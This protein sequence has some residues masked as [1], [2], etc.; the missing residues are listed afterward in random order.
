ME[1]IEHFAK[2]SLVAR[3]LGRENLISREEVMRLQELRGTYG[4]KAPAPIC[5]DLRRSARRVGGGRDCQAADP[6]SATCQVVQA[7]AAG[8]AAGPNVPDGV[9]RAGRSGAVGEADDEGEIRLTYRELSA[10]I[11]DAIRK[12]RRQE[13]QLTRV[14]SF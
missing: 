5:A 14:L 9:W 1:T 2:I 11:E 13:W 7:P 4:I 12:T 8:V 10:L 6:R 3:M